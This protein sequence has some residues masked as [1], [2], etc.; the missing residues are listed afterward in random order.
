MYVTDSAALHPGLR[1]H[2]LIVNEKAEM[3]K[4]D[5]LCRKAYAAA[6]STAVGCVLAPWLAVLRAFGGYLTPPRRDYLCMLIADVWTWPHD[7]N[8]LSRGLFCAALINLNLLF[9]SNLF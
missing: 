2:Y 3:Y 7:P 1:R 5:S 9:M 8:S 6:L 4:V